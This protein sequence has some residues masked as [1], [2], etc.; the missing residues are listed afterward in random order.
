M[1]CGSSSPPG[2]PVTPTAAAKVADRPPSPPS[3]SDLELPP[4]KSPGA[5]DSGD[6]LEKNNS[7]ASS[8]DA[9]AS[10]PAPAAH[11]DSAK[12]PSD[13]SESPESESD[14][15]EGDDD[16]APLVVWPEGKDPVV[17][18]RLY[19]R[20]CPPPV[21]GPKAGIPIKAVLSSRASYGSGDVLD[22]ESAMGPIMPFC[23]FCMRLGL[24]MRESGLEFDT[25]LI[26]S[27]D[28][29]EWFVSGWEAGTTPALLGTP[30]GVS[31]TEWAGGFDDSIARLKTQSESF[32]A[33]LAKPSVN[34][35]HTAEYVAGLGA[36]FGFVGMSALIA[37]TTDQ[38][39]FGLVKGMCASAG[40]E[41]LDDETPGARKKRLVKIV[42]ET[43]LELN[44]VCVSLDGQFIGGESPCQAD[45]FLVTMLYFANSYVNVGFGA[46]PQMPCTLAEAGA[47]ALLPYMYVLYFPNPITV[48]PYKLDPFLLQSQP[49]LA[50]APV[51]SVF[52]QAKQRSL[53]GVRH[54][55]RADVFGESP[56][57]HGR[58]RGVCEDHATSQG[59]GPGVRR[60]RPSEVIFYSTKRTSSLCF[61]CVLSRLF[62]HQRTTDPPRMS[63]SLVP[64]NSASR[65]F[66]FPRD[67]RPSPKFGVAPGEPSWSSNGMYVRIIWRTSPS[68]RCFRT[69][70]YP[71]YAPTETASKTVKV[72]K[73]ASPGPIPFCFDK[74]D[75]S[76]KHETPPTSRYPERHAH[77]YD[78][79]SLTQTCSHKSVVSPRFA[80]AHSS[81][82]SQETP[83]LVIVK[84]RVSPVLG[85]YW[86]CI[87][88]CMDCIHR[89]RSEQSP[90]LEVKRCVPRIWETRNA[91]PVNPLGHS[92]RYPRN[93]SIHAVK[94]L[95]R[96]LC[97]FAAGTN[98]DQHPAF[99]GNKHSLVS[100]E[101]CKQTSGGEVVSANPAHS[102]AST[103]FS[104]LPEKCQS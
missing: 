1:G 85:V 52:V 12:E 23:P 91:Y 5:G 18:G 102:A 32:V 78:P 6:A 84:K 59:F 100:I 81:T 95:P 14:D 28:K 44:E 64:P 20:Q 97:V 73:S 30:G 54:G 53:R 86:T 71:T 75:E 93:V 15:D 26:D 96:L 103:S 17:D 38:N 27:R 31:Q 50:R 45:C 87:G 11:D 21:S 82:S 76:G 90:A 16:D 65:S 9:T 99:P 19:G 43:L 37:D 68:M 77:L 63:S 41:C 69:N 80:S 101:F 74:N 33:F 49:A 40:V 72:T 98:K 56:G 34:E 62:S 57:R 83:S 42:Q 58:R 3:K 55:A 10:P 36:K 47:P 94:F 24:M 60:Q 25:Y 2:L 7:T 61:V 66:P 35:K 48:C 29:P 67:E 8:G 79:I 88:R 70:L 89:N 22:G 46:L 51:V 104:V 39:G 4:A 13:K 92:H